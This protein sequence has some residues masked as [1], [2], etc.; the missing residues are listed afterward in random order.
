MDGAA[1]AK[2]GS[3]RGTPRRVASASAS[4]EVSPRHGSCHARPAG[5]PRSLSTPILLARARAHCARRDRGWTAE[6]SRDVFAQPVG[7]RR[8]PVRPSG[9]AAARAVRSF[10]LSVGSFVPLPLPQNNRYSVKERTLGSYSACRR[11]EQIS[12]T[13]LVGSGDWGI[14]RGAMS[15]FQS[16]KSK[17]VDGSNF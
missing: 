2:H 7:S 3:K 9:L 5:F 14:Q 6:S 13:L 8:T 16:G 4:S 10:R 11:A 15:S 12:R 17:F 1:R